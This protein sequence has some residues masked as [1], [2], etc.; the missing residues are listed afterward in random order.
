[1][2]L[3][4]IRNAHISAALRWSPDE[5]IDTRAMAIGAL[6]MGVPVLAGLALGQPTLGFTIGLGAMLLAGDTSAPGTAAQDRPSSASAVLPALLAVIIA[7]AIAGALWT[8]A[9]MIALATVAAL[10][11]GYSRPVAVAAVRFTIY[12]VLSVSLLENATGHHGT[13]ALVFGLGALWN[14]ALRTMLIRRKPEAVPE[15]MDVAPGRNPTPAQRRT[16]WRRTL[17]NLAGWQFP[18]RIMAGLSAASVIRHIWPAHHYGWIIVT[19]AL[20]TQR[21]LEHLPV[22]TT[23]RAIG[24]TIGVGLTWLILTGVSSQALLAVLICLLATVVPFARA[25]SYLAY[26]TLATPVILL[27]MDI[28]KPVEMALLTDRLVATI[29]AAVIVISANIAIDQL[30]RRTSTKES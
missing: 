4:P 20:L 30:I 17:R 24:T 8:D 1:M 27:V 18:I 22:K 14:V 11:S 12:L 21:P 25:R 15:A 5:T 9:V 10:I 19:V 26:S 6:G 2:A 16:H 3:C 29:I 23:Q 13:A 28:G 7:T